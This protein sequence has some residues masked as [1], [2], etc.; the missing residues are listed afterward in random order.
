MTV[1]ELTTRLSAH[2]GSLP[3]IIRCEWEGRDAGDPPPDRTFDPR[4]VVLEMDSDTAE[5]N[6]V[7]ECDQE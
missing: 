2:D 4:F 3:V 1:K 5:E 7:V 6:V